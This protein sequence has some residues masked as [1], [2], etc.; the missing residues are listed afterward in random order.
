MI[1]IK[2]SKSIFNE[3]SYEEK[4]MNMF[5][6]FNYHSELIPQ[7]YIFDLNEKIL[8]DLYQ[9]SNDTE[10]LNVFFHLQYNY[11]SLLKHNHLKEAA[12]ICYLISYYLFVPLTPPHSEIIALEYASQ[13]MTLF[14]TEKY[15]QWIEFVTGK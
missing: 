3:D 2:A 10:Q 12:Y 13:A 5:N 4:F 9:Q 8:D 14:P 6:Y 11:I 7:R 15:K 1:V